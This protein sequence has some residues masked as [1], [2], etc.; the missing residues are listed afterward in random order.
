MRV[1][2]SVDMEGC[3]GIVHR[4]QTDPKGYDYEIARRLMADEANAAV[5]GAFEA[6]A[7]HVV[8]SDSHGGNG[9]RN[10]IPGDL[11]P[12]A[13]LI[14]GVPRRLG[15][16]EGI[17]EGYDALLLVGYHTRHGQAGVLSHTTNGQAVANLWVN[18]L[19][20][21]EIGLN[22]LLAA[23]FGVPTLLVSGDDL[24]VAEG[25]LIAPDAEGVVVKW[26]LGRYAAR[27][28]HPQ[29]AC[30]R[31]RVGTR[32]ALAKVGTVA[33]TPPTT[34]VRI[35]LQFKE[36]GS[37]EAAARQLG[38]QLLESDTIGFEA[39]SMDA[40]YAAYSV[41]VDGWLAAWGNWTKG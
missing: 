2:I 11:D 7:S 36:S 14:N 1:Y 26:A 6:G 15:Q 12:R 9:K 4:E 27:S 30:E 25:A 31:I 34:P 16:L 17:D 10:L 3:A 37:A 33:P 20:V 5:A 22:A 38:A 32:A 18:D 40:A 19:I 29:V 21:G 39:P 13:Q 8:V 28:L 24:T 35:R 23:S 41:A